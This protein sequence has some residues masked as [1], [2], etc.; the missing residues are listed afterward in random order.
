M[1]ESYK[2]IGNIYVSE[3]FNYDHILNLDQ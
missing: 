1:T 3:L 2:L